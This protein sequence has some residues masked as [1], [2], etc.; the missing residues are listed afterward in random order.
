MNSITLSASFPNVFHWVTH[1]CPYLWTVDLNVYLNESTSPKRTARKVGGGTLQTERPA[2][3][4]V[5]ASRTQTFTGLR[6]SFATLRCSIPWQSRPLHKR[7]ARV[8]GATRPA[9][10]EVA[11]VVPGTTNVR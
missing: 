3:T 4:E 2:A 10:T 11:S 5:A 1:P 8:A 9:A 6:E 7:T